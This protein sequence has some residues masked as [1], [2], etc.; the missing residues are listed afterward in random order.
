MHN[1]QFDFSDL[2]LYGSAFFDF[3]RLRK[4][5][6][7]DDLKWDIPHNSTMEMDQYDTPVA[8]Y[9]LVMR[10]GKVVGGARAMP[11][12]ATWGTHTYML[13]DAYSGKLTHIPPEVMTVEIASPKVWE[14]TRLVISNDLTTAA[15]RTECLTNIV[16]G[17]V[18]M[19]LAH[20][21]DELICL[22]S[23]ALMRAL[24]QIGYDVTRLCD[25][26]RNGEDGRQYAVLHMPA[27]YSRSW[28]NRQ[29][30]EPAF[31]RDNAWPLDAH[32]KPVANITHLPAMEPLALSA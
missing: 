31:M 24:R 21:A 7:V 13:R 22:S 28:I 30:A 17:L 6:F 18:T 25:P 14:C 27:T 10:D 15:E 16:D 9:S 26:Y 11:T 1:I 3:L 32:L 19:T 23:L 29:V 12:T 8:H 5:V 2:H 20:G 4:Q